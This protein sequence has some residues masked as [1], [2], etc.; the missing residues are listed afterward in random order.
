MGR[1]GFEMAWCGMATH[2]MDRMLD[3][4]KGRASI[5]CFSSR[6]PAGSQAGEDLRSLLQFS[7]RAFLELWSPWSAFLCCQ[8]PGSAFTFSEYGNYC[9]LLSPSLAPGLWHPCLISTNGPVIRG[10]FWSLFLC[11]WP[12]PPNVRSTLWPFPQRRAR[13]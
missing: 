4:G 10:Y 13:R 1:E 5:W 9:T 11:Q 8:E 6:S 7:F 3:L 2:D 12:S